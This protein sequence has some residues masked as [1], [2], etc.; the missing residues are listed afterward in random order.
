MFQSYWV[1]LRDLKIITKNKP[2]IKPKSQIQHVK[3]K[4]QNSIIPNYMSCC[5][6]NHKSVE[7]LGN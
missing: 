4:Y 3:F 1:Q 5:K 6:E 2:K 7:W